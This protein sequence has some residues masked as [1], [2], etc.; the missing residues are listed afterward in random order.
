MMQLAFRAEKLIGKKK[1]RVG[2]QKRNDLN[3]SIGQSSKKCRSSSTSS[4]APTLNLTS[5]LF[6]FYVNPTDLDLDKDLMF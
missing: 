2:F 4:G 3:V 6:F 5:N 1:T